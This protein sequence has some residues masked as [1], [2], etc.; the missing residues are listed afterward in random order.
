VVERSKN[1]KVITETL[2]Y[3]SSSSSSS[4]KREKLKQCALK[5]V[6]VE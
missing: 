5:G 3:P 4:D 1:E 2:L 6:V